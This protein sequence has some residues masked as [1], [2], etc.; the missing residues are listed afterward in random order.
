MCV[1]FPCAE[2]KGYTSTGA[3]ALTVLQ[4]GLSWLPTLTVL[5]LLLQS[6]LGAG[7]LHRLVMKLLHQRMRIRSTATAL[8]LFWVLLAGFVEN[9]ALGN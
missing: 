5:Q 3:S 8:Q 9:K 7:G 1:S 4:Q 2:D 6:G